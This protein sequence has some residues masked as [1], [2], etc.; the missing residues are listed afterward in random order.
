MY[1]RV[2]IISYIKVYSNW[3]QKSKGISDGDK[4][5]ENDTGIVPESDCGEHGKLLI[6]SG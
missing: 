4:Y 5:Q 6:W 1:M 2:V 3:E